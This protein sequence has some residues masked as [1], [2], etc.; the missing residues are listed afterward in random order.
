MI[1][2]KHG[3]E[4]ADFHADEW[5]MHPGG[6]ELLYL[7]TGALDVVLDEPAG[8]RTLRPPGR[9]GLP[10]PDA[11]CGTG[12]SCAGRAISCSSRPPA[13]RGTGR[14]ARPRTARSDE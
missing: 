13:A 14:S 4:P 1:G 12:S 8:E 9:P 3:A 11:G 10:R 7:L 2:A 6:D 5:E